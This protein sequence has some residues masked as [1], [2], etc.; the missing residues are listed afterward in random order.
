MGTSMASPHAAGAFALMKSVYPGLTPDILDSMLANGEL[1]TDLGVAGR[2]NFFGHGLIDAAKA[3]AAASSAGGTTPTNPAVLQVSP[4]VLNFAVSTTELEMS[5]SNA[6]GGTLTVGNITDDSSGWLSYTAIAV[7]SNGLGTYRV[8]VDRTSLAVGVYTARITVNS[9]VGSQQVNVVMQVF[10]TAVNSNA[11]MQFIE[12]RD[13]NTNQ[14]I[15]RLSVAPSQGTYFF[16]FPNVR[17]GSYVL[18]SSSDLDG[19]RVYCEAAEACGAYPTQDL[20]S[21]PVIVDGSTSTINS[22]NFESAYHVD[23]GAP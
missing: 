8:R 21:Q 13:S 6:G 12:L 20:A 3:V 9:D 15:Q 16:S 1:T 19:D 18:R 5:I 4:G 23:L 10:A 22:L 11:S 7:D 17:L 2:D 14:L